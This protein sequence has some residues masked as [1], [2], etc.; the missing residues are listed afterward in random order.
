MPASSVSDV[1][2]RSDQRERAIEMTPA[3]GPSLTATEDE[4]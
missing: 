1:E 4:S 2:A 3:A